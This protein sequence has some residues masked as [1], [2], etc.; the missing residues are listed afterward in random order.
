MIHRPQQRPRARAPTEVKITPPS[1]GRS[2]YN[3]PAYHYARHACAHL[4][5]A[6]GPPRSYVRRRHGDRPPLMPSKTLGRC[7]ETSKEYSRR[8]K[9]HHRASDDI[10]KMKD[11]TQ[12]RAAV[13]GRQTIPNQGIKATTCHANSHHGRKKRPRKKA[14]GSKESNK[15]KKGNPQ[16]KSPSPA[17]DDLGGQTALIRTHRRQ[18]Q[19]GM[20]HIIIKHSPHPRA[21]I[22][23]QRNTKFAGKLRREEWGKKQN[24]GLIRNG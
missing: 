23:T 7:A 5:R 20:Q 16:R 8:E 12:R 21:Y 15:S 18:N 11:A 2:G 22:G 17:N 10:L 4:H 13:I 19:R 14:F 24:G 9:K 6:L 3:Y 1:L